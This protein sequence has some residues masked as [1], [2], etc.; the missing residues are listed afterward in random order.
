MRLQWNKK[1]TTIAVYALIVIV[2]STAL[3]NFL[4]KTHQFR[5]GFSRVFGISLPF[6]IGAGLA[7]TINFVLNFYE[8]KVFHKMQ[9]HKRKVAILFSY[10]TVILILLLILQ[11]LIPELT[12]SVM[13]F[14]EGIPDYSVALTDLL[15]GL[16][17]RFNL[18]E[19]LME[20]FNSRL[21]EWLGHIPHLIG[22]FAPSVL[23]SLLSIASN[24]MNVFLGFVVS[25]YL[26]SEK[27]K[28][29][30]GLK[31]LCFTLFSG[32]HARGMIRLV[33]RAD[34]IFGRYLKGMVIDALIV[35][36][37][38]T[39]SMLVFRIPY[40]V[41][42]G[43]LVGISNM[44]PYFGP[45]IGAIPSAII[46]LIVSPIKALWFLVL[47]VVIQQIDG[48][49]IAPKILGESIGLSPF[50]VL[51]STLV[52]GNLFGIMG[53]LLGV[54]VFAFILSIV[55]DLIAKRLRKKSLPVAHEA[56]MEN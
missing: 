49:F 55:N 19:N 8:E 37:M 23:Q 41:L 31:R 22:E 35:G 17:Q 11:W 3:I 4:W 28:F 18:S 26:L 9:K 45:F 34:Q 52:F 50:W 16:F 39:I 7:Y 44:I 15:D 32:E 13:Q 24:L 14:V 48:N 6:L 29:G 47:I 30:A 36:V 51:F 46:V 43:F 27:E 53:L 10:V 33:R 25:I 56:Y 40:A 12:E 2:L 5:A 42:I 21:T 20:T 38:M 54:P 1:Y